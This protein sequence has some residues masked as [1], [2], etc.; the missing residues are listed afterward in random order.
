M[1]LIFS[2]S[3]TLLNFFKSLE[4]VFNLSTSKSPTFAFQLFRLV[5]TLV[6]LVMSSLSNSAFKAA[7]S[8]VLD[9]SN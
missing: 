7:K 5:G 9:L 6:S 3:P 4:T 2:L 8:D 1:C